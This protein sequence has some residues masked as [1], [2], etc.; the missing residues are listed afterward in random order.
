MAAFLVT[1]LLA[2]PGDPV[3]ARQDDLRRP[4]LCLRS[5]HSPLCV[6]LRLLLGP[7]VFGGAQ[8]LGANFCSRLGLPAGCS[9]VRDQTRLA[10]TA[11]SCCGHVFAI[12]FAQ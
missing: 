3:D 8:T 12:K 11:S 6:L 4:P 10:R 2:D 9:P 1:T 5:S 7:S